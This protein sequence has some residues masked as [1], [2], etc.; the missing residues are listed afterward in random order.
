[1]AA[2]GG[3]GASAVSGSA[4]TSGC[5]AIRAI[6]H[7]VLSILKSSGRGSGG[8]AGAAR[9]TGPMRCLLLDKDTVCAACAHA[10]GGWMRRPRRHMRAL[11]AR[12]PPLPRDPASTRAEGHC[13]ARTVHE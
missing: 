10:W 4:A 12:R 3:G 11:C 7:Y 9:G 13:V 5:D 8:A 1:M 2:V 6:Q